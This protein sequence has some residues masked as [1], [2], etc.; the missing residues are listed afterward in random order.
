MESSLEIVFLFVFLFTLGEVF[1]SY[2][3]V[4]WYFKFGIP[5]SFYTTKILYPLK[6]VPTQ[7]EI[8]DSILDSKY[9]GIDVRKINE[10]TFAF[11]ESYSFSSNKKWALKEG[12]TQVIRGN[13]YF[14]IENNVVG[15]KALVNWYAISIL[16]FFALLGFTVE[17]AIGFFAAIW[18]LFDISIYS[19]QIERYRHVARMAANIG[20]KE[21]VA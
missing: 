10:N 20:Q 8:Q 9:V 1:L 2:K 16:V 13:L 11:R 5:V 15:M 14:D 18:I 7:K 3:F 12:Y 4:G 6:Q 17:P 19:T 21:S